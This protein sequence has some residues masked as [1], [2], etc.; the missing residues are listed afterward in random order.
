VR[1]ASN[2][3]IPKI[4]LL[5]SKTDKSLTGIATLNLRIPTGA[6]HV[7]PEQ[8]KGK[9]SLCVG[10][11]GLN[12]PS[13]III[14]VVVLSEVIRG[15]PGAPSLPNTRWR[16]CAIVILCWQSVDPHSN[17]VHFGGDSLIILTKIV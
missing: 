11:T 2:Q 1:F 12:A 9:G 14:D 5:R 3:L 13:R 16:E 15:L 10:H 17:G 4:C 8:V 6:N 7:D